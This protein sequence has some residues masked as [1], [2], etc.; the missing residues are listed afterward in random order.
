MVLVLQTLALDSVSASQ[1]ITTLMDRLSRCSLHCITLEDYFQED[2]MKQRIEK[3]KKSI[4]HYRNDLLFSIMGAVIIIGMLIFTNLYYTRG[5]IWF[6]LPV[7]AVLWWPAA[8][9]YNYM[10][11]RV[12]RRENDE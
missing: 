3:I 1:L 5:I 4:S 6:V 11:K 2:G 8:V 12:N 7:L 9:F 10:N